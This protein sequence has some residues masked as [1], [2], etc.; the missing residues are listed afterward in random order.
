[1]KVA[2]FLVVFSS[3][4]VF[5]DQ[6]EEIRALYS[7]VMGEIEKGNYYKTTTVI[8]SDNASYPAVGIYFENIDFYWEIDI[9]FSFEPSVRF[10]KI[11]S[12]YSAIEE[13][14]E[15]L[16]YDTGDL[17]FV[18]RKAGIMREIERFYFNRAGELIRFVRGD[19]IFELSDGDLTNLTEE[20][21]KRGTN[22]AESFSLIH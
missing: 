9:E 1:M 2:F 20:V 13:Y 19:E 10:V 7:G 3:V 18:Y 22:L 8:N 6:I 12:Q 16:Y 15:F 21:L 14:H 17:A 5:A 11:N 4:L